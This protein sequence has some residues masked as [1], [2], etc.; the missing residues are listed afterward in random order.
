M[1]PPPPPLTEEPEDEDW[2]PTYADALP[3]LMAFC[4]MLAS[5]S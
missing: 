1:V 2:L 4:V 3:L 5:F